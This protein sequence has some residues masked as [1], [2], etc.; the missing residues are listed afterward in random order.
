MNAH[1]APADVFIQELHSTLPEAGRKHTVKRRRIAAALN[2]PRHDRLDINVGML[3]HIICKIRSFAS[4]LRDDDNARQLSFQFVRNKLAR[5]IFPGKLAFRYQDNIRS[6]RYAGPKGDVAAVAP[7]NLD[8]AHA[9]MRTHGVA[10]LVDL[11]C[12]RVDSRVKADRK[13]GIAQVIVDRSRDSDGLNA[14]VR[15][16]FRSAVT[17]VSADNDQAFNIERVEHVQRLLESFRRSIFLAAC[18]T[19]HRAALMH[20]VCN[21]LVRKRAYHAGDQ[22]LIAMINAHHVHSTALAFFEYRTDCRVHA[23]CISAAC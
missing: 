23:R 17:A 11:A 2:I 10:D 15:K 16:H 13:I 9:V 5:G 20:D 6:A 1:G 3:A 18:C 4:A 7:H 19:Q 8:H 14:T 12:D 22:A 21:I